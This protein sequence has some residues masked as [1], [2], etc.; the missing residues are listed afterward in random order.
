MADAENPFA[1]YVKEPSSASAPGAENPFTKYAKKPAKPETPMSVISVEGM[2]VSF[3]PEEQ[4]Q[5]ARS[6]PEFMKGMAAGVGEVPVGIAQAASDLAK[7]V[8]P[9][10]W[11]DY[12]KGLDEKLV[13]A[14]KYLESTGPEGAAG[15]VSR[16]IGQIAA[17]AAPGGVVAR[18]GATSAGRGCGF[19][20]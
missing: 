5:I 19:W 15:K 11:A 20:R 4:K 6:G 2:P 17:M 3:D 18:R 14:E 1:K 8:V 13:G 12:L 16:G 7:K 9:Q 10:G